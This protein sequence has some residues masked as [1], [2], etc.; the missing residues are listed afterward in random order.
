MA[1]R[2]HGG[3]SVD[4]E[5]TDLQAVRQA[6]EILTS[7]PNPLCI[8]PEGE[9]YHLND[10]LTPF[11]EGPA[12]IAL[13]AARKATRPVV[14]I[15]CAIKYRYVEDPTPDLLRVME[16]LERAILWRPRPD[17]SLGRANLPFC[18][19]RPGPQGDRVPRSH[20]SGPLPQR[21]ADLIDFILNFLEVR[22]GVK[23]VPDD[24]SRTGQGPAAAD[25]QADR[26]FAR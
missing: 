12:A 19:G 22:H 7:R 16:N 14:C 6:A 23:A 4:R 2:H 15:P 21:L 26:R 10:R 17:L 25:H 20:L 8:F 5:G 3:F 1:L 9:V 13:M 11:R 24:R 18:R